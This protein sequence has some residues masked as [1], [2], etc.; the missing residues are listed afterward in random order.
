MS[1]PK[2]HTALPAGSNLDA[3][4][5]WSQVS[6]LG[7]ESLKRP[8][9]RWWA[10]EATAD[11]VN[12]KEKELKGGQMLEVTCSQHSTTK[13]QLCNVEVWTHWFS[14]RSS[15]FPKDAS[16]F[17]FL[18]KIKNKKWGFRQPDRLRPF[19]RGSV[20]SLQ[21]WMFM[22]PQTEGGCIVPY[23]DTSRV[24]H[25]WHESSMLEHQIWGGG[26]WT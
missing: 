20:Y 8:K 19:V 15:W 2:I 5:K 10:Y 1:R 23:R 24:H 6:R 14:T 4:L 16:I 17:S 12:I 22:M 21:N 26:C 9:N 13:S 11:D 18:K 7:T 25:D 3:H